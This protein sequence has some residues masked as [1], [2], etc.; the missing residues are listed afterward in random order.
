MLLLAG[1]TSSADWYSSAASS[2]ANVAIDRTA[3]EQIHSVADGVQR[4]VIGAGDVDIGQHGPLPDV[5]RQNC[6]PARAN[7]AG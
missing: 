3:D 2:Y 1:G 7:G 6:L 4:Q 5:E